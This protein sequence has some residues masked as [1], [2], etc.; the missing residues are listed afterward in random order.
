MQEPNSG[1][2]GPGTDAAA[3]EA[4]EEGSEKKGQQGIMQRSQRGTEHSPVWC[5]SKRLPV[6]EGDVGSI[7]GCWGGSVGGTAA[8]YPASPLCDLS[9]RG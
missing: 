3:I 2:G 8:L 9:L 5:H 1:P 6:S 4:G 7:P